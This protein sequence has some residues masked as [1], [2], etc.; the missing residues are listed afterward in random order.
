[1]VTTLFRLKFSITLFRS[2][3]WKS[4]GSWQTKSRPRWKKD[5]LKA[6]KSMLES[7]LTITLAGWFSFIRTKWINTLMLRKLPLNLIT[8]NLKT[9]LS[10]KTL[11]SKSNSNP[12]PKSCSLLWSWALERRSLSE[13]KCLFTLTLPNLSSDC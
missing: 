11:S 13:Q 2:T 8:C 7:R 9:N 4:W 12:R 1:M 10:L 5:K 3:A 6:S